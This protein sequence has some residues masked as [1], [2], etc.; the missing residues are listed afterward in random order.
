MSMMPAHFVV[1]NARE[2]P[3]SWFHFIFDAIGPN[4]R[5]SA[6]AEPLKPA[7]PEWISALCLTVALAS[8]LI[9]AGQGA[10][11]RGEDVAPLLF[12]FGVVLLVVP[13]S[14]RIS[15][16]M[17][18]R[19]ERLFLLFLLTEGL[20]Y[21]KSVYSP[22]SFSDHDEFLHWIA[23]DDLM[24]TGRL[25]LSNPLLP[26][27]PDYPALEI[28]TSAI[29]ETTKLPLFVA[30]TLLLA[31]LRSV[32]VGTLFL[33]YERLTGSARLSAIACLVYMGCSTFVQFDSMFSY[34]SLGIVFCMLSFAVDA[35]FRDFADGARL[36]ACGL[37]FL[38]LASLAVTHHLSAAYAAIYFGAVAALEFLRRGATRREIE[39]AIGLAIVAIAL[40]LL[41]MWV[42][43]NPLAGYLGPVIEKG[44]KALMQ[45]FHDLPDITQRSELLDIP[46]QPLG[47]RLT[48]MFAILLL[49]LGLAT[50]FFRSLAIAVQAG[51][52][53]GWRPIGGLLNRR[54]GDSRV[55][56][57]T[58]LV[59]GFPV[60]VA[61]RLTVAGWEIG[62]RMGAFV[63]IAVGLVVAVSILRFWEAQLPSGWHR[64]GPA[65]ALAVV[66]M[67]GVTASSLKPIRGHYRA[68]GDSESIEP[69]AVETALW[70][71]EWLG[72][73][74]RFA[75]DRVNRLLL[76]SYGRQDPKVNIVEG[77][78]TAQVYEPEKL[79]PDDL[80]ALARSD[81]DFL[82]VDMRLS[83]SPPVLGFYFD[84]WESN[85]GERLSPTALLKFD[86]LDGVARIYDNDWIK[87]YDVRGLHEHP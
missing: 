49:A 56:F 62:N 9:V 15:W 5:S 37:I 1:K 16:P 30:G 17:V 46:V 13:T 58:F 18:A 12:W 44:L 85:Q 33:L 36:R 86:H 75:A 29:V 87:I 84:P 14:F 4:F 71:K 2:T 70:T 76:A 20:F 55:V 38:L 39:F 57:L 7:S 23:A 45:R 69:M 34:E 35:A 82:L 83:M 68:G 66:V 60:S 6:A 8:L 21:Y 3:R 81:L 50:G 74:N 25:F 10:G 11:R 22:T 53:A 54:W 40:P 72:A 32:F 24:T 27:G 67:G 65:L 63:F 19:G 31:V 77:V 59:F 26:I 64:I 42:C 51:A 48:T 47:T 43:G 41:W 80:Y 78:S 52:G 61:F 28:L 79:T 73:G